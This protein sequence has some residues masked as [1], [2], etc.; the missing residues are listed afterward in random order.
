M[1]TLTDEEKNELLQDALSNARRADFNQLS[2]QPLQ[3]SAAAHIEFLTWA[4]GLSKEDP[5]SREHPVEE[6]M[7]L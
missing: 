5:R 4:S 7:L 3:L 1:I 6:I 2:D